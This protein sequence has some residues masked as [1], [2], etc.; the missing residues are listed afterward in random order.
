MALTLTELLAAQTSDEI[1]A[2]L[3]AGLNVVGFPI[4]D[5]QSGGVARTLVETQAGALR[6]FIGLLIPKV[7]GGGFL[8]YASGDWLTFLADQKYDIDRTLATYTVQS[9]VL[10]DAGAGPHV[11][12]VGDLMAESNA[13]L[14]YI[15][16]TGG[17]IPLNGSVTLQ[18][19]AES[20]GKAYS[21]PP[22]TILTLITP[23]PTVTLTNS[24]PTFS[25]VA[26]TGSGTG[27]ATLSAPSPPPTA[28][29]FVIK[30]LTSGQTTAATFVYS[31]DGGAYV[32]GGII[33][34]GFYD[35]PGG[36]R[37]TF[38]NG[39][40]N[41]S[42]IAGDLYTFGTPG[43]P[44]VTQGRDDETD[45]ALRSRC[46][47]RWPG[48]ADIPIEDK[49]ISWSKAAD[50]QVT[51]VRAAP[52]LSVPGQ[53]D[54]TIAGDINPLGAGVVTAVQNYINLR[55]GITDKASVVTAAV[56]PLVTAGTV[57]VLS[58]QLT[59][60]QQA[61]QES[62]N[63]YVAA[64]AIGAK[65]YVSD[66]IEILKVAGAI[67]VTS[68]TLNG[69]STSVQL[70]ATQVASVSGALSSALTWTVI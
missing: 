4:N 20:P 52:S 62:W 43:S 15:N 67:D 25:V 24:S 70:T 36:T 48:L 39:A 65:A 17:T 6:D 16:S 13:G 49:Y 45:E 42:F 47:A 41:P 34:A 57:L 5:W 12:A 3:F 61:A 8:D 54:V 27:T 55:A 9:I 18:F 1:Q 64:L 46:S 23:L 28:H 66:L 56:L 2:R 59:T 60:V 69:F 33:P 26:R 21:D 50:T 29:V 7:A 38:A 22:G 35:L 40:N 10:T 44:I 37:V 19:K 63:L 53:V 31:V 51:K 11:V 58:S 14:R 30:I 68:I 32:S